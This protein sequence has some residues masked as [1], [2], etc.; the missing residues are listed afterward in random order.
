MQCFPLERLPINWEEKGE[1]SVKRVFRMTHTHIQME[2]AV[3]YG[4]ICCTLLIR[5]IP[6]TILLHT[7]WKLNLTPQND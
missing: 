1:K 5:I 6:Y 3:S 4:N 7:I 2:N